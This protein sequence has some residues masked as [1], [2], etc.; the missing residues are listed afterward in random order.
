[1]TRLAEVVQHFIDTL[2]EWVMEHI[3]RPII[4][5]VRVA[6]PEPTAQQTTDHQ[7]NVRERVTTKAKE[8]GSMIPFNEILGQLK[9]L[10]HQVGINLNVASK[11][12]FDEQHYKAVASDELTSLVWQMERSI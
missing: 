10:L 9:T 5:R 8:L 1:M 7:P 6:K 3:I 2:V 4:Q 11:I 12:G